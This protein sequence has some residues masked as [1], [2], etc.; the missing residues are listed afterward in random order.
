MCRGCEPWEE[1]TRT[2][3]AK[4]GTYHYTVVAFKFVKAGRFGLTPL[5]GIILLIV[6]VEGLKAVVINIVA[7]EDISEEFQERGFADT[8]LSNQKDGVSCLKLVLRCVDDPLLERLYVTM[9]M[10]R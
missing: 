1:V 9:N 4:V 6:A 3:Y 7:D 10:V 2:H 5:P 8:S